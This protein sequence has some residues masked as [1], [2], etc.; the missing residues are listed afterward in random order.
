MPDESSGY[1]READDPDSITRGRN[2]TTFD[3]LAPWI[4]ALL[5][6]SRGE[7]GS[8][9]RLINQKHGLPGVSYRV[10]GLSGYKRHARSVLKL[11]RGI[12][13]CL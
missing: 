11:Y 7:G 3:T 4:A 12:V 2:L 5:V 6:E 1:Q 13:R 10:T 9:F 8:G